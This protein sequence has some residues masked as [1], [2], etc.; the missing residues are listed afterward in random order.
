MQALIELASQ[1]G[2]IV[3]DPFSGSG[4]TAIAASL[5]GRRFI[6][7]EREP[8]YVEETLK[9]LENERPSLI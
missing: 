4:T 2:Q 6:A 3:L 8:G 9:R 5:L 1:P 7:I